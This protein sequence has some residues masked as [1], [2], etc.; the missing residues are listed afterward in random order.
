MSRPDT[1]GPSYSVWLGL[2]SV[3]AKISV[4]LDGF[5]AQDEARALSKEHARGLNELLLEMQDSLAEAEKALA[6][7][8][9]HDQ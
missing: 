3:R 8:L 5:Y 1:Q 6:P 2:W 9:L 4:V 7:I